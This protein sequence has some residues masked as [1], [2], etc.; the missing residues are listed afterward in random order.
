[1]GPVQLGETVVVQGAGPVGLSAVLVAKASGAREIIVIDQFENRLEVARSLGATDTLSL[2]QTSA[3]E[4]H[5]RVRDRT[6][7]VGPNVVIEAAGVLQAFP[8]GVALAGDHSRYSILGLWGAEGT[9]PISPRDVTLKNLQIKGA[10]FPK[11]KH[12][13]GAM[14]MAARLEREVP[15]AAL[16]SHR[17][18][19][20]QAGEAL[21]A[22]EA[23]HTVKAVIEPAMG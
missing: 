9:V 12:Y 18:G 2:T 20:G 6:G 17:F 4:R 11:P 22:V 15:L 16:I 13:Y 19:I 10:T 21:A 23:G 7:H 8:E 5:Q 3:E 14:M 1:M